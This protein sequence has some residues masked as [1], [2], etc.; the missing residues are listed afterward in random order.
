MNILAKW[1]TRLEVLHQGTNDAAPFISAESLRGEKELRRRMRYV[2]ISL[3]VG[4]SSLP[5]LYAALDSLICHLLMFLS[6]I[7]ANLGHIDGTQ[8]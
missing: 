3:K 5:F 7:S 1:P 4:L 2:D 8:K 6:F